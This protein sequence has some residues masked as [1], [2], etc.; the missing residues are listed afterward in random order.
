MRQNNAAPV[1]Y[2]EPGSP[3]GEPVKSYV[4]EYIQTL[5]CVKKEGSGL[6]QELDEQNQAWYPRL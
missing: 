6:Q 4:Y 1:L 2:N 3:A 5:S